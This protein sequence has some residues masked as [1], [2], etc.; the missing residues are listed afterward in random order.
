MG[1]APFNIASSVSLIIAQR[2][3]RRL[4][5]RCKQ[6]ADIP[7]EVL[8]QQGFTEEEVASATIFEPVGCKHCTQGFK[9]RVGVYEVV[10][11]SNDMSHLIM[12]G[13]NSRDFDAQARQEGHP[14]LRRSGLL[15]V[16]QGLTSLAEVNRVTKD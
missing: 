14:D 7:R 2:L 6:P 4:C 3:A 1:V 10:P 13:G 16:M 12:T 8:L 5:K 9:G 11:I 15:K